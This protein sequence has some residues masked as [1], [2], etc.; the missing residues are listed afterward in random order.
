MITKV[1][2]YLIL[3]GYHPYIDNSCSVII[4]NN[5]LHYYSLTV[6]GNNKTLVS[7]VLVT[8]VNYCAECKII[9]NTVQL[10]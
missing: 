10:K 1:D 6:N 9:L 2:W 4:E 3:N 7:T 5:L 8:I